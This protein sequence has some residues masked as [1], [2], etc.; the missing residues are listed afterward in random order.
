M[1]Q[2][3]RPLSTNSAHLA[4][5]R[6]KS[7]NKQVFRALLSIASAA[8][9]IRVM[10]MLNQLVITAHFGAGA[11]M[12]AYF[13]AYALPYLLAQLIINAIE[14]SVIPVYAGV[15][16][17]GNKE[18]ASLLFS[19]L[20]NLLLIGSAVLAMGMFIFRRQMV[21]FSAPAL[22]PLRSGLSID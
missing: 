22:D 15:R 14:Y 7:V 8:L 4:A 20:L 1:P 13:V 17:Q 19:T 12:D 11:A 3:S 9:L 10:G 2:P 21:F 16:L 5:V 6:G 18:Q